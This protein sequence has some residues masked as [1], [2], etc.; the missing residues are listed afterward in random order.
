MRVSGTG[1]ARLVGSCR[2]VAKQ[3]VSF[4]EWARDP[5]RPRATHAERERP[6]ALLPAQVLPD[7]A[8]QHLGVHGFLS[9]VVR[10]RLNQ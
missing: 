9:K 10:Q 5:R 7:A 4:S 8:V 3:V 6:V 2:L 1:S